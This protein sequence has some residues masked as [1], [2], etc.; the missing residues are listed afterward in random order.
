MA[1]FAGSAW[2]ECKLPLRAPQGR[3]IDQALCTSPTVAVL[4]V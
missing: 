1:L 2:F 3:V 4:A